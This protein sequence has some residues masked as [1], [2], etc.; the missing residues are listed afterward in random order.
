MRV[1]NLLYNGLE[2]AVR[3]FSNKLNLSNYEN[4]TGRPIKIKIID[5]ISL[6]LFMK[7]GGAS[8]KKFLFKS[9]NLKRICSYKTLVVSLNRCAPLAMRILF[10]IMRMNRRDQ[11]LVKLIDSS[12]IE[13]CLFK[14]ANH[15]KTM[16]GLASFMRGAKGTYFGLKIHLISDLK[17]KM[18]AVKITSANVDDRDFVIPM[19]KDLY[20]LFIA[21]S[22]Y[23]SKNLQQEFNEDGKR[24]LLVKPRKNM[25]KL[26]TKFEEALYG[27]R[28]TIELT[29]RNLKMFFGL[30][31]SL[32]R[33]VSGYFANY[34]YSLLACAIA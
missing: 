2:K 4:K 30:I 6:A 25:K 21:D 24:I 29:F 3:F 9:F 5:T 19:S 17:R 13:V 12:E 32:P 31:T 26:M 16:K 27:T 20:G 33:S 22:G 28:M 11:H 1:S 10:M 8:T 18:L 23:I 34:V 14:N 7:S 15:H